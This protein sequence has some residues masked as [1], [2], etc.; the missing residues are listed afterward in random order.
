M[1]REAQIG[2]ATVTRF[3][4]GQGDPNPAT[5]AAICSALEA[6]GVIFVAENGEGAGVR[7]RKYRPGVLVKLRG[8]KILSERPHLEERTGIVVAIDDRGPGY[9]RLTVAFNDGQETAR[10]TADEVSLA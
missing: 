1:A 5:L 9:Y 8:G 7:L 10:V 2:V 6:A 3:E 4:N